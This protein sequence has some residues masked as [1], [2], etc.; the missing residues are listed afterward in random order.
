MAWTPRQ[1]PRVKVNLPVEVRRPVTETPI[2]AQTA[3]ICLGGCYVE[4]SFTQDVSAQVEIVLWV[5]ET[6]I[7]AAGV[8]V[9]SHPSVG[10]GLK[11]THMAPE[12]RARLKEYI[13][14]L[15]TGSRLMGVH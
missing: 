14:S 1:F 5:G 3:D 13:D 10:N 9:S 11:F 2:R 4:M 7:R 12:D 15:Q 6:K 8:I